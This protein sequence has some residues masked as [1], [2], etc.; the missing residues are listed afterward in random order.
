MADESNRE[1]SWIQRLKSGDADAARRLWEDYFSRLV[2]F[3]QRK[4]RDAPRRAADEEDVALS[5]I[6]S[7]CA[8]AATGQFPQL[9]D[10]EDLWR[11]LL[12]ITA[13]KASHQVRDGRRE[14]RG[15]GR[16]RGE[17][18]FVRAGALDEGVGIDEIA[19]TEA[20]PAFAAEMADELQRLLASLDDESVREVAVLKLQGFANEEIAAELHCGLRTVERRLRGIRAI[21]REERLG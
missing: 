5:A 10:R 11:L 8:R 9:N 12:T 20:T 4:L 14:K 15:H 21:W 13:R 2:S 16:V 7:F 17:S 6:N 18:A 1:N 3:A 19:D